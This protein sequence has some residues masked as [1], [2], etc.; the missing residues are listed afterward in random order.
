MFIEPTITWVS[1]GFSGY[2]WLDTKIVLK[3]AAWRSS[4]RPL[5][6]RRAVGFD[7]SIVSAVIASL[8]LPDF[9][10]HPCRN[11]NL[12]VRLGVWGFD[13]RSSLYIFSIEHTE[14]IIHCV[15]R[16]CTC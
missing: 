8:E 10:S 6:T 3:N 16:C 13:T 11:N 5:G 4:S 14:I 7:S 15:A 9:K 2:I 1:S 12:R